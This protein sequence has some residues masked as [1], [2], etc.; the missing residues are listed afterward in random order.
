MQLH[1][2]E[3]YIT[4]RR[5]HLVSSGVTPLVRVLVDRYKRVGSAP[6]ACITKARFIFAN[7]EGIRSIFRHKT[8][9]LDCDVVRHVLHLNICCEVENVIAPDSSTYHI[10]RLAQFYHL[11]SSLPAITG[12]SS[13]LQQ[14]WIRH[15]GVL[16]LR[17]RVGGFSTSRPSC[18]VLCRTAAPNRAT[19][20]RLAQVRRSS[21]S[22]VS[23]R[24]STGT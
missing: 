20:S 8:I 5:N 18:K 6:I 21:P 16:G 12:H 7:I 2:L 24:D 22:G 11:S 4:R 1:T 23:R 17:E 13:V 19:D 10:G 14:K 3:R 9:Q 15:S